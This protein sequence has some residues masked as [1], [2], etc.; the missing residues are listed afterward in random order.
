VYSRCP[1][2]YRLL[3]DDQQQYPHTSI[4]ISPAVDRTLTIHGTV[5]QPSEFVCDLNIL[6]DLEMTCK[7]YVSKLT[8]NH[9]VFVITSFAVYVHYIVTLSNK[10]CLQLVSSGL[11]QCCPAWSAGIN[12]CSAFRMQTHGSFS[13]FAQTAASL[14]T[15]STSTLLQPSSSIS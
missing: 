5:L 7:P 1:A 13:V 6:F 3:A 11:L 12:S 4:N 15:P 8:N 10:S 2:A 14:Q 9:A